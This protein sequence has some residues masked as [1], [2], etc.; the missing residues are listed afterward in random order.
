MMEDGSAEERDFLT[1]SPEVAAE[2]ASQGPLSLQAEEGGEVRVE[3]SQVEELSSGG[4]SEA[5]LTR[6]RVSSC[7]HSGHYYS[8][9][10]KNSRQ[11]QSTM[12]IR[13][14]S[15][16]RTPRAVQRWRPEPWTV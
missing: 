6:V 13:M 1:P 9:F 16:L 8:Y 11:L 7:W 5:E 15:S 4:D 3:P 12:K 10:R 14:K 2:E